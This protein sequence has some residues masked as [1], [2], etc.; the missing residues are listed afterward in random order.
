MRRVENPHLVELQMAS[1]SLREGTMVTLRFSHD[2]MI[3]VGGDASLAP[4]IDS[5]FDVCDATDGDD[6]A[7]QFLAPSFLPPRNQG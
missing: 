1:V 3:D 4:L 7:P 2:V 5:C 6:D